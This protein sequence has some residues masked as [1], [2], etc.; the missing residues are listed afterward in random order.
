MRL[1]RTP[2]SGGASLFPGGISPP[3]GVPVRGGAEGGR[4]VA[5][6]PVE[7]RKKKKAPHFLSAGWLAYR[8]AE[9]TLVG[10]I[11]QLMFIII[12]FCLHAQFPKLLEV[13]VM[14]FNKCKQVNHRIM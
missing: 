7:K 10:L 13:F 6:A 3:S 4:S 11:L 5:V 9:G 1:Q 2:P 12:S 8:A 14:F